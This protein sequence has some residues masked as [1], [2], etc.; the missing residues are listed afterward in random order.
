STVFFQGPEVQLAS[1]AREPALPGG[2]DAASQFVQLT[3]LFL[4][5]RE[6]LQPGRIVQFPLVLPRRQYA[7]QYEVLGQEVLETPMGPLPTWH[8]RPSRPAG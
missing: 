2:Q 3:W 1:G 6:A 8:L 7:W 4:T 5:G